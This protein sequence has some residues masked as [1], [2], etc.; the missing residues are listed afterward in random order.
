M[1]GKDN[2]GKEKT[3]VRA[4]VKVAEKEKLKK[5]KEQVGEEELEECML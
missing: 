5:G 4:K 1:D 2:A 3:S